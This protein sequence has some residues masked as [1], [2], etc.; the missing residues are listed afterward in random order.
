MTLW[1]IRHAETAW[2]RERRY[3]GHADVPLAA[4]GLAQARLLAARLARERAR[5]VFGR[6]W[7]SDL[8]RAAETAE[9]LGRA[10]GLP[11]TATP[12]LREMNF[13]RWEGRTRAEIEALFPENYAAYRADPI[14]VAPVGGESFLDV[15]ER[16]RLFLRCSHSCPARRQL[17]V[18]HGATLKAVL[19]AALGLPPEERSRLVL[20][21]ASVT[22]LA[23]GSRA[24]S[25]LVANDVAHLQGEESARELCRL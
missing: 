17:V 23:L 6:L 9:A 22:V 3:Q 12:L 18:G 11:V 13:G 8:R 15:L 20:A 5:L 24:A 4:E 7:S 25:L 21:N 10:V 1:L 2:N 16:A 19:I 14:R